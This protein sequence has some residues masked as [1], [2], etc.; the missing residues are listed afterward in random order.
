M[1]VPL[2]SSGIKTHAT[3]R[4][5]STVTLSAENCGAA[6]LVAGFGQLVPTGHRRGFFS[7]I[8][9]DPNQSAQ[10][11]GRPPQVAIADDD[12]TE[13]TPCA[14]SSRHHVTVFGENT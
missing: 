6:K 2:R 1:H 12:Y 13:R 9:L 3:M 8:R 10:A 14:S 7:R 11:D 5:R 4:D